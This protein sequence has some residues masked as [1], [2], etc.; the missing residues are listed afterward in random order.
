MTPFAAALILLA[1]APEPASTFDSESAVASFSST[2]WKPTDGRSLVVET[3]RN[4]LPHADVSF[5]FKHLPTGITVRAGAG[6]DGVPVPSRLVM[7]WTTFRSLRE[8][9]GNP[10]Y[11]WPVPVGPKSETTSQ[12]A[13]C[14]RPAELG[15]RGKAGQTL[16]ASLGR[17]GRE[18]FRCRSAI[19]AGEN[20]GFVV[21]CSVR[22]GS[23]RDADFE[24]GPYKDTV[25]PGQEREYTVKSVA[26]P[27][28]ADR[29]C[30][31]S[32]AEDFTYTFKAN[33]WI[34]P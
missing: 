31:V 14:W 23:V 32:F 33:A 8:V 19:E 30:T 7:S 34:K 15:V 27:Q 28:E 26:A 3:V 9:N 29:G 24:W 22:N 12:T 4:H 2:K 16:E 11:R 18:L 21:R 17:D 6:P 10:T 1:I 13:Q 20:G 25:K 5:A